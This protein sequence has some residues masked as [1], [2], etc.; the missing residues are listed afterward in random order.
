MSMFC[1]SKLYTVFGFDCTVAQPGYF[2]LSAI[3]FLKHRNSFKGFLKFISN[4]TRSTMHC[5]Y[6]KK[7]G[8]FS[9]GNNYFCCEI[10]KHHINTHLQ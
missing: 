9:W 10:D 6:I 4:F 5:N 1:V 7:L 2:H 3:E 8:T